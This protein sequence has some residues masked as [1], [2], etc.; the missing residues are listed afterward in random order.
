MNSSAVLDPSLTLVPAIQLSEEEWLEVIFSD[1][2]SRSSPPPMT[3]TLPMMAPSSE[4]SMAP[5]QVHAL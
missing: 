4:P 2:F 5:S 1:S 3:A